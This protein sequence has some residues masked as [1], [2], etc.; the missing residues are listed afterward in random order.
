MVISQSTWQVLGLWVASNYVAGAIYPL[1]APRSAAYEFFGVPLPR[2]PAR[3]VSK[4]KTETQD[5]EALALVPLLVRLGAVRELSLAAAM[6]AFARRGQ[7]REVGMVQLAGLIL[8]SVDVF[9]VW[10]G[11]G[12][13]R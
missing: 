2:E 10:K 1:V 4:A 7:W 3:D 12:W 8:C 13:Q 5:S 6:L 9:Y 11:K